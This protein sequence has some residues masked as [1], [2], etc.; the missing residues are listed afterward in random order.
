[1]PSQPEEDLAEALLVER[2]P[3]LVVTS[4]PGAAATARRIARALGVGYRGLVEETAGALEHRDLLV[5]LGSGPEILGIMERNR[6]LE[7][8][9]GARLRPRARPF[10]DR[11]VVVAD[12]GR[13]HDEALATAVRH[14]RTGGAVRVVL[15]VVGD[16]PALLGADAAYGVPLARRPPRP[17]GGPAAHRAQEPGSGRTDGPDAVG[18]TG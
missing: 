14:V 9:R 13:A 18:R 5:A 17:A 15:A 16:A 4:L 10:G 1:M 6:S 8:G 2:R 7:S 3:G 12:D 11:P